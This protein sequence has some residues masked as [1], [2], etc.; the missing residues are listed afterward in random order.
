LLSLE[1]NYLKGNYLEANYR[2]KLLF[3]GK[4]FQGK[5]SG[6]FFFGVLFGFV[7]R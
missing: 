6:P 1:A 5:K 4:L 7:G 3:R 2:G